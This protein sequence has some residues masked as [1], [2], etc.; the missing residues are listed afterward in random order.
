MA[1]DNPPSKKEAIR[2]FLITVNGNVDLEASVNNFRQATVQYMGKHGAEEELIMAGINDLYDRYKGAHL[3]MKFIQ[4]KVAEYAGNVN[5]T[6]KDVS[7]YGMLTKRIQ[8]TM[9]NMTEKGLFV[10]KRGPGGGFGRLSDQVQ[11]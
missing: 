2:A 11:A 8:D 1:W 4:S 10:T 6:L 9:H 3:N 7:L 5:Q